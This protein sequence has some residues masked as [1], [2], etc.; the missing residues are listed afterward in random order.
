MD[1][2]FNYE[3]NTWASIQIR[4]RVCIRPSLIQ[5]LTM[6]RAKRISLRSAQL[7]L[8]LP[9]SLFKPAA[10][11]GASPITARSCSQP[12]SE[13][14]RSRQEVGRHQP[15]P[16]PPPILSSP[17]QSLG[18]SQ[19]GRR[20]SLSCHPTSPQR[21]GERGDVAFNPKMR[22]VLKASSCQGA[23]SVEAGRSDV[24]GRYTSTS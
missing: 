3:P 11:C 2:I 18:S 12:G 23:T 8:H 22:S 13:S 4:T 17:L 24:N 5:L 16:C 6:T 20:S 1:F 19:E 21:E 14:E 7:A 9:L 15:V 10:G